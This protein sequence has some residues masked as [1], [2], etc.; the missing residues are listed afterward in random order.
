MP[1]KSKKQQRFFRL[2]KSIQEG[3]TKGSG[4][5][6]EAASIMSKKDVRDYA[7]TKHE[8]LPESISSMK[9]EAKN[10][11][12]N[13]TLWQQAKDKA[14]AKFSVYPSAYANGWA[15][16]WYK[17]QGG[18]WKSE[19][20]SSNSKSSQNSNHN[21]ENVWLHES[22]RKRLLDFAAVSG[23]AGI[24]A[25]GTY[26]LLKL[27]YDKSNLS[28]NRL[29]KYE[30]RVSIPGSR[31]LNKKDKSDA[32]LHASK[33]NPPPTESPS[34][35]SDTLSDA[36][37]SQSDKEIMDQLSDLVKSSQ[38]NKNSED[39]QE[40]K[41]KKYI[42]NPYIAGA[43][44][45]L[46]MIVPGITTFHFGKKLIDTARQSKLD[47]ELAKAK[48]EFEQVLNKTSNDL[49]KQV[50]DL[51]VD[52]LA[53][54]TGEG[55][56]SDSA[57]ELFHTLFGKP[58]RKSDWPV[59]AAP[60]PGPPPPASPGLSVGGISYLAGL[61]VGIGLLGGVLL[62]N[63]VM[64]REPERRHLNELKNLLKRQISD[65]AQGPVIDI[66][67]SPEGNSTFIL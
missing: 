32:L 46:A 4:K 60:P 33:K 27:L 40:S 8:N 61:P 7:K 23:L 15:A 17:S 6:Q 28:K 29:K 34:W 13:P 67:K 16:K 2:V 64:K 5:A 38:F 53:T 44:T 58:G 59:P 9:K 11:P 52:G 54:K 10:V 35:L 42:F 49:Q 24:G 14:K 50:N 47:K 36:D 62:M 20:E 18:G 37:S 63:R 21:N 41:A 45:P 3:N 43:L 12:S 56:F 19:S 26:G 48:K 39:E 22:D 25:A 55:F 1:A 51:A 31:R 65:K 66:E 57:A 30:T